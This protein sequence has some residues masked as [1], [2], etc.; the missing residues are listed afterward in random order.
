MVP[1][2]AASDRDRSRSRRLA[3]AMRAA[4]LRLVATDWQF[5]PLRD[6]DQDRVW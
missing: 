3:V 4:D 5:G 2:L 6:C 1:R